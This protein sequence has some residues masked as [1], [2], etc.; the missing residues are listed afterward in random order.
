[1]FKDINRA[2]QLDL[3]TQA[4]PTNSDPN[5]TLTVFITDTSK[6]ST[7]DYEVVFSSA[8]QFSVRRISDNQVTGPLDISPTLPATPVEVDGFEVRLPA[9]GSVAAGDRFLLTPTRY[10]SGA[11]ESV[12]QQPEELGFAAPASADTSLAN[13]GTAKITQP[14]L[15]GGPQPID[16]A[17][18]QTLLPIEMRYDQGTGMLNLTPAGGTLTPSSI[19]INPGQ[20]NTLEWALDGYSFSM[21]MTGTPLEGDTF[22][23]KFNEGKSDN[24]N[25]LALSD[26]QTKAVLG[27]AGGRAG[28]SFVDGY[29]DLVQRVATF[30]AQA[31]SDSDSSSAVL[32]Q[33][34]NNR[35]SVSAVNLDEEAANLIKFEQ[36][37]NASAQV[38]QI[39]R[40][41]FD[42]LISSIR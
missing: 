27:Q 24:R 13:R 19:A 40:S 14:T 30:T 23:I 6:L 36:Y 42:T 16:P 26:L 20:T 15:V 9:G 38:L 22:N 12:M 18:M 1:L 31:R 10:G 32:R 5:T 41:L 3:R 34:T 17:V 29:G 11:M 35:D 39:A 21:K 7:S 25:A 2:D 28:F 37:Y 8:T 33:A 4:Q